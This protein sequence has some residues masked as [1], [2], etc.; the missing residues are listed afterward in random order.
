MLDS[1]H[2]EVPGICWCSGPGG[3]PAWENSGHLGASYHCFPL[4]GSRSR[5]LGL[6]FFLFLS[7]CRLLIKWEVEYEGMSF[8]EP[9]A[10]FLS[11]VRALPKVTSLGKPSLIFPYNY[12]SPFPSHSVFSHPVDGLHRMNHHQKLEGSF[13]FCVFYLG[14]QLHGGWDFTCVIHQ[15]ISSTW[16]NVGH[17]VGVQ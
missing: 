11:P 16:K 15:P 13:L 17:I 9:V 2:N 7:L 12:P 8:L 6:F 14:R 5:V 4:L 3:S 1:V 10:G